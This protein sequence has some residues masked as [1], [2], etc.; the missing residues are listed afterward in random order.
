MCDFLLTVVGKTETRFKS[1]Q[2]LEI[3][4]YLQNA[5]SGSGAHPTNY[6]V[7]SFWGK[8]ATHLHLAPS[9]RMRGAVSQLPLYL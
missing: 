7:G 9:L 5:E 3:F 1:Q 6:S 4:F 8:A 2:V